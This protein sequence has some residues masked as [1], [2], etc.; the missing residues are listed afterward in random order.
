MV[1]LFNRIFNLNFDYKSFD[2]YRKLVETGELVTT[3]T[4][5]QLYLELDIILKLKIFYF[6]N[7]Q[8]QINA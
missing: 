6:I 7:C 3:V 8:V 1:Y 4:G 2:K 5:A